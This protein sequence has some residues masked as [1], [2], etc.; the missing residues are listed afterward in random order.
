MFCKNLSSLL[1]TNYPDESLQESWSK[2]C[3]AMNRLYYFDNE[4]INLEFIEN[5]PLLIYID[6]NLSHLYRCLVEPSFFKIILLFRRMYNIVAL[7]VLM[8]ISYSCVIFT[9]D[10]TC[11][12]YKCD[13]I[14]LWGKYLYVNVCIAAESTS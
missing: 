14:L 7:Y 12:S 4:M 5:D 13:I 2:Y 3:S 1:E 11:D 10:F 9:Y 8:L 6:I